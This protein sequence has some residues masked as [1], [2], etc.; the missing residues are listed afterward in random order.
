MTIASGRWWGWDEA[1]I[2]I[3]TK[4]RSLRIALQLKEEEAMLFDTHS[5]WMIKL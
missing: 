2:Q 5:P 1:Y 4:G 3:Q